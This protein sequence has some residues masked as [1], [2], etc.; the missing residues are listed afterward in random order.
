MPVEWVHIGTSGVK[1]PSFLRG[2]FPYKEK[3]LSWM[4][5]NRF[6]YVLLQNKLGLLLSNWLFQGM[7]VSSKTDII[8][9]VVV[10]FIAIGITLSI[11]GEISIVSV[12]QAFFIAHSINWMFNTHFWAMGR[13]LGITRTAIDKQLDYLE[14]L[15]RRLNGAEVIVGAVMLGSPGRGEDLRPTSDL[16]IFFV[17]RRDLSSII[18]SYVITLRERVLAF[19]RKIPLDLY[20]YVNVNE[21]AARYRED[22]TPIVLLDPQGEITKYYQKINREVRRW[23]NPIGKV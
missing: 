11:I 7:H 2:L 8:G 9:K 20:I 6:L 19:I 3:K 5:G 18:C 23:E 21:A 12:I 22:E 16:D 1:V 15:Q 13:Y 14:E 4:P 10:E 17:T